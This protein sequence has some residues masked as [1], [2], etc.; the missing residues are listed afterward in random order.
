MG[1]F[2]GWTMR[3]LK[4]LTSVFQLGRPGRS[5]ATL[6]NLL[7]PRS[8]YRLVRDIAYGQGPR[9]RFDLYIPDGFQRL[10][11]VVLFFYGGGFVAGR[12]SEYRVVGEALASLGIIVAIADYRIYPEV[13]FPAFLEDG[14]RALV[15]VHRVVG[16]HGGDH[17]RIFLAGHS[18]GGYISVMLAANPQYLTAA[19]AE[20]S[21]IRGVIGIAG[22]YDFLPIE[23][24][25]LIAI[26]GGA[27]RLETQPIH[28]IDGKK[29]PMLLVTGAK[30]RAVSALNTKNLAAR[31]RAHGSS[32]EEIVYPNA[33]HIGI[34]LALA[35]GF[36][37]MAPLREDMARFIS[38]H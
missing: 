11:P 37:R 35:R 16:A 13:T 14:A 4:I 34:V 9:H 2:E 23:G 33:G 18:A 24:A 3:L 29:P 31:L 20:P 26:F 10:A 28:F 21:W 38:R 19:G 30:D 1:R 6:L 8:G 22:A 27:N 25:R 7:A 36:R 12:R 5:P 32:V 15:A 17:T